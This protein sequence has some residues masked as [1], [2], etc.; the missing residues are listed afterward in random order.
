MDSI[1]YN[2]DNRYVWKKKTHLSY[3]KLINNC[4]Q[5]HHCNKCAEATGLLFHLL[6]SREYYSFPQQSKG[7]YH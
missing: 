1:Y 4:V 6:Y 5:L 3:V 2:Y 7:N